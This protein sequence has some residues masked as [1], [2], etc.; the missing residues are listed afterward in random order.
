[1]RL[2]KHGR[3]IG[4]KEMSSFDL[5]QTLECGQCFH[6]ERVDEEDYVLVA[7]GRMLH[8]A[9]NQGELVLYDT[10]EAEVENTWRDYFDLDRDYDS[11]KDRLVKQDS[12][13]SEPVEQMWGVRILNQDF[14]E[15]LMSFIIS[16]NKQI[17][18]IKQIV[19]AISQEYGSNVG[20]FNDKEYYTFPSADML[21]G[22]GVEDFRRLKAGFR[23]PYLADAID[24][25]RSGRVDEDRLRRASIHDCMGELM[26]VKGVGE[27]VANCV[28]LFSLGHR[29][30]F[31]VD[32]WIK[33]MMEQM[34]FD[35]A[36]TPKPVIEQFATSHFGE[37]GGYAQQYIFYFGR[38]KGRKS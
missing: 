9:Q 6:F 31:P 14:F 35:G 18:H 19:A 4:I 26:L 11:I 16:Q 12:R 1:M 29:E 17:P 20:T 33:R 32:V 8:V 38:E 28:S 36:D 23:A 3:D 25:V 37:L 27:K 2:V 5:A 13:L 30:A 24:S 34:Y 22:A 7:K 15:T 10:T 21:D